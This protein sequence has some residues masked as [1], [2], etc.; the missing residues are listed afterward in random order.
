M[1]AIFILEIMATTSNPI[2]NMSTLSAE[3]ATRE[4]ESIIR[5]D[6]NRPIREDGEQP[7]SPTLKM[8]SRASSPTAKIEYHPRFR[9]Q[10][11]DYMD[12]LYSQMPP[13]APSYQSDK[14]QNIFPTHA[15]KLKLPKYDP[16]NIERFIEIYEIKCRANN[17]NDQMKF[18]QL[19]YSF[20]DTPYMDYYIKL[21]KTKK[22]TDWKTAKDEFLQRNPDKDTVINFQTILQ[23][24]QKPEEDVLSYITS[25]ESAISRLKIDLPEN[26]VVSQ[27]NQGFRYDIY[28]RMMETEMP[29]TINE[30]IQRAIMVEQ[31]VKAI[32]ERKSEQK[33]KNNSKKVE[34]REEY[35]RNR[36]STS[37]ELSDSMQGTKRTADPNYRFLN[38]QLRDI[39][40]A[41]SDI[42]FSSNRYRSLER[43]Q[44]MNPFSTYYT[45]NNGQ[46]FENTRPTENLPTLENSQRQAI[47]APKSPDQTNVRRNTNGQ[48]QCY[49]CRKFGHFA[50]SCPKPP[51][52][53][54]NKPIINQEN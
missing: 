32:E 37:P 5:G 21:T 1:C 25:Q 28:K 33:Y 47:E 14:F 53:A 49:N 42:K 44:D 48:M 29:N 30:L 18:N 22:I 26:F 40:K 13:T 41:I 16:R 50:R 8:T 7:R 38:N 19:I 54:E 10:S 15:P 52:Q 20:E 12:D 45:N 31:I 36:D 43:N 4:E 23:R 51:R 11:F 24:K 17:W 27:I 35:V 39:R 6:V 46:P 2:D 34:F 3:H 9:T